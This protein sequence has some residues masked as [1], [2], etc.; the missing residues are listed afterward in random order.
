MGR[1]NVPATPVGRS[2][3]GQGWRFQGFPGMSSVPMAATWNSSLETEACIISVSFLYHVSDL[4]CIWFVSCIWYYLILLSDNP[5]KEKVLIHRSSHMPFQR[6]LVGG[7]N[8]WDRIQHLRFGTWH[9]VIQ[10]QY[11]LM[12]SNVFV[13]FVFYCSCLVFLRHR[14]VSALQAKPLGIWWKSLVA[15]LNKIGK[16]DPAKICWWRSFLSVIRRYSQCISQPHRSS[17]QLRLSSAPNGNGNSPNHTCGTKLSFERFR[18]FL[19]NWSPKI[20]RG[21]QTR[22]LVVME[23]IS[24]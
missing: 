11:L 18:T 8:D 2:G 21:W 24:W 6:H 17:Q 15:S 13:K 22:G 4:S 16:L 14:Y 7:S 20:P 1:S 3:G 12:S 23:M 19:K 10:Y 5:Q 9:R